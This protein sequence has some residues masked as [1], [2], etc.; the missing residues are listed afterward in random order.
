M[1]K[2]EVD[3]SKPDVQPLNDIFW[4]RYIEVWW[5]KENVKNK[6]AAVEMDAFVLEEL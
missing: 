5:L 2:L 1:L 3:L 4:S 6:I